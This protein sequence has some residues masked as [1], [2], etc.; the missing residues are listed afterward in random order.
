VSRR[1]ATSRKPAKA[2]QMIK[3]KRGIASKPARNRRVSALS[4]DT[5]VARL[6]RELAEAR[7]QQTATAE[8]LRAISTSPGELQ[9]VFRA[10]LE[11][12]VRICEAKFGVLYLNEGDAFR[13]AAMR[14]APA[15]FAELRKREPLLRPSPRIALGRAAAMKKTVHIA[16]VLAEPGYFDPLPGFSGS[17]IA[18]L[19]GARTVLAVPMLKEDELIGVFAIYRQEVRPFTDKQIGLVQNFAA[20][21]VIAIENTRLLNELRQ[22]TGDL[23]EA[24]EHQ[25]A[26]SEVLNVISRSPTDAQPVFDAIVQS[27]GRLCEA[28]FSLV[29]RYDGDRLHIAATHNFTPE[30]LSRIL[31]IYPKRPDRSLL[32]GRAVLEGKTAH[33]PDLLADAEYPARAGLGR[34]VACRTRGSY[35]A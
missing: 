17:Q 7:E 26:T 32:A 13:V 35:A 25:T 10:M 34:R 30:V 19:A 21:A 11:N 1:R 29:V 9:P 33:V 8:V 14:N 24:L 15:A 18:A 28:V 20:Q 5:E 12:A 4:K 23:S 6:A 16:D 2:Q 27:A 22:R 31:R 3:A